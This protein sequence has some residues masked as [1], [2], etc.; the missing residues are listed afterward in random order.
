MRQCSISAASA[1]MV[2]S[3]SRWVAGCKWSSEVIE[4][5]RYRCLRIHVTVSRTAEK[6]AD[7]PLACR[8]SGDRVQVGAVKL[9]ERLR[10]VR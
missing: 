9:A 6:Q 7:R 8:A 5:E 3:W 10:K 4:F 2:I 1:S